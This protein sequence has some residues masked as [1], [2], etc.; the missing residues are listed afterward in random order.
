MTQSTGDQSQLVDMLQ[1]TLPDRNGHE[2]LLGDDEVSDYDKFFHRALSHCSIPTN[3]Y[4][5][6]QH[7]LIT[8]PDSQIFPDILTKAADA[9]SD[10]RFV[11]CDGRLFFVC[12]AATRWPDTPDNVSSVAAHLD[13]DLLASIGTQG[14][15]I[16]VLTAN[17]YRLLGHLMCGFDLKTAADIL[18]ANYDTKRK[19]IQKILSKLGFNTQTSLLRTLAISTTATMLDELLTDTQR[20]TEIILAKKHYGPQI[21]IN[22]ISLGQGLEVPVWDFG[23]RKDRPVLFFH[24]MLAPVIF[25]EDL[26]KHLKQHK[27]RLLMIP[28]HFLGFAGTVPAE[29]RQARLIAAIAETVSYMTDEPL[30][31]L[32][33]SAGCSWAVRFA[34]SHPE[35][36][37]HLYL[38]A[39]P[40][41]SSSWQ[42][43]TIFTDIS[44]RLRRDDRVI[45]GI[46]RLY[47]AIARV[48]SLSQRALLHMYRTS[49]ADLASLENAFKSQNLFDWLK[50]IAN[51]ALSAS[52]DEFANLQRDWIGDLNKLNLPVTFLHGQQDPICPVNE[53]ESFAH[54]LSGGSILIFSDA[55]HFVIGQKLPKI[56]EA[57]A[58]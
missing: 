39:T 42:R 10:C 55:G 58:A 56:L 20:D 54:D 57:I 38:A 48:P 5:H 47:N 17:E 19:Q 13:A 1:A 23:D 6:D 34:H 18:G 2:G 15:G 52:I 14:D 7:R 49:P 46:T 25:N 50:L 36:V 53:I 12:D 41:S 37:A 33:D 24:S 4:N 30:L 16:V 8:Q 22:R 43:P 51:H 44:T 31:C 29:V 45:A 32:G 21:V 40:Q 35:R 3:L 27:L 9:T 11:M 26:V 28:R